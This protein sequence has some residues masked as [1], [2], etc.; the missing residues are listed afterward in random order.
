MNGV[1]DGVLVGVC[2]DVFA[3]WTSNELVNSCRL[4]AVM[5]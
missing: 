4:C 2:G 3:L 1:R 5:A